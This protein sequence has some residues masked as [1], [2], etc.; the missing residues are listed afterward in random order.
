MCKQP[1]FPYACNAST[2]RNRS[3]GYTR[4]RLQYDVCPNTVL[5]SYKS[6]YL[7]F[8]HMCA[9]WNNVCTKLFI[10]ICS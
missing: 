5:I 9:I 1:S 4:A 2:H 10:A 3:L 7:T 8:L 6:T